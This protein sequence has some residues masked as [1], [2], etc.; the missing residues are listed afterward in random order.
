MKGELKY[1]LFTILAK[2]ISQCI[3][4]HSSRFYNIFRTENDDN[5]NFA[6]DNGVR[7]YKNDISSLLYENE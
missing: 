7:Q 1:Q 5:N 4:V 3:C 6:K 2:I